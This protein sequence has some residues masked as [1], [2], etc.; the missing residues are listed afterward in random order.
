[1]KGLRTFGPFFI[2]VA[3]LLWSADGLLR[4]NLYSLPPAVIVFYEHILGLAV[5]LLFFKYWSADIKK[6]TRNDWIVITIIGLCAGALGTIFYTAALG[7]IQYSQ[8]SVVVLLQQLEPVFAITMAA[9]LLKE[10]ITRR[11]LIWAG[12]ALVATY[13]ISF[14]D[15]T[16]NFATGQGTILA[17]FFAVAAAA[18]W[19]S[20]T[21]LGR[22]VLKD[23]S[24]IGATTFR[25]ATAS[26]FA[27][28]IILIL[29]Q[30]SSMTVLTSAQMLS[31]LAITFSTGVAAMLLYYYGLKRTP[32]RIATV[33]ELVWPASAI[34]IDYFYFHKTL[35]VTQIFGVVLLGV[36][37]Y[38]VTRLKT[39]KVNVRQ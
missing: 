38:K 26:V 34:V 7:M 28:L 37:I 14:R 22:Y 18:M 10:K 9:V 25:Y 39:G 2:I 30:Q 11:F 24:F 33:C 12:L 5:M 15:L 36:C 6:M 27:L 35:S 21:S 31:L 19:G 16:V 4:V 20:A 23:I 1:M 29:Q 8:Y 13:M 17:A 3:S 32:A